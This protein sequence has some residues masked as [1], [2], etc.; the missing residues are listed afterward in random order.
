MSLSRTMGRNTLFGVIEKFYRLAVKLFMVPVSL[1]FIGFTGYGIWEAIVSMV[2]YM[3]LGIGGAGSALQKYVA[4]ATATNQY[5]LASRRLSGC[6]FFILGIT[7]VIL[8]PVFIWSNQIVSF[9][10]LIPDATL[11]DVS[12]TSINSLDVVNKF[13]LSIRFLAI[14]M[15]FANFG[16]IYGAIIMGM[17]RIDL[18]R[19]I[20][21]VCTTVEAVIALI[22]LTQGYGIL[23]LV[24]AL[25]VAELSRSSLYF[26]LS[27]RVAPQIRLRPGKI[28]RGILCETLEFAGSYQ[29]FNFIQVGFNS[30]VPLLILKTMGSTVTG[31]FAV[32]RRL[33]NIPGV[34]SESA[35][36]PLL[37]GATLVYARKEWEHFRKIFVKVARFT[38]VVFLPSIVFLSVFSKPIFIILSPK[39]GNLSIPKQSF[40]IGIAIA[41]L[42]LAMFFSAISRVYTAMYRAGGGTYHDVLLFLVKLAVLLPCFIL[43]ASHFGYLGA[44]FGL[45]LAEFIGFLYIHLK[46]KYLITHKA[47]M[48]VL[49]D[50]LVTTV[51]SL[52]VAA[53]C[54]MFYKLSLGFLSNARIETFFLVIIIG[55]FYVF[56][57]V[58]ILS[59][60]KFLSQEEK[61]LLYWVIPFLKNR[62]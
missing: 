25:A 57:G 45:A 29:L 17:H 5:E 3:T 55:M 52:A 10:G 27:R 49:S 22:M 60:T 38:V 53:T 30:I 33:I 48:S 39:N 16:T 58:L 23:A 18:A 35:L 40:F 14:M 9:L 54:F 20:N 1:H 4:E 11:V 37:S 31:I 24:I 8:I 7:C 19:I 28:S 21:V 43:L 2:A 13:S 32:S 26:I 62:V 44:L 46:L 15:I 6:A 61:N 41:I 12:K 56:I 42:G 51:S 47:L 34:I 50:S 59:F 36:L